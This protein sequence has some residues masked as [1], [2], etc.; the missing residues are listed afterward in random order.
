MGFWHLF[1]IRQKGCQR[2]AMRLPPE[3]YQMLQTVEQHMPQLR[4]SQIKGLVLWVYGT[5]LAGSSC[6]NA[7][8]AALS[9]MGNYN[10]LRQ[11]IR[12]WLY[13]GQDRSKPCQVQLDVRSCF[14]PLLRW[15][16]S[17]W[18]S[19][20]LVLAIDPTMKA[21]KLN[22]IVISV[23]Y[24]SCAIPV[25]WHILPANSPGQW[26][27]PV[28]DLL[29]LLSSA[30]PKDKTVLV[31]CDRGLRSPRLWE[32]IRS[33]G[34]H[35]YVR[36]SINTVFCPDGG[37]RLPARYLVPGPGHAWVGGGTAFRATSIRRRGTM[38]VVWDKD[39]QEPWV[40]MTDLPPAEA[41]VCWYALR[42]WIELGFK[43][44][45]SVGWQWQKTRRTDPERVSRHWLVLS[46]STLLALAYGTRV[47]D[48]SG[49][50]VNPSRL[51]APPKFV[52][53]THRSATNRP[54]R[55]V[56]VLRQGIIWLNRLLLK[57]R[58]WQRVWLLP[59]AWPEPS[60]NLRMIYGT[61]T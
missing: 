26:I 22:S 17:L 49:L 23:V 10:S 36:Q 21:D 20:R 47:E 25:A 38:I 8:S 45:K 9:V 11:Y 33:S 14:V 35:P 60:P 18:Q 12:E 1:G 46:V 32:Q 44:I 29:A 31:M 57:G 48:A 27:S 19:D 3:C 13:D 37:T 41:G 39:Q 42:F 24:R 50:G 56:S 16:L 34:W 43:A 54:R 2:F 7:V 55:I 15:V 58:L 40:V 4:H 52:S 61:D 6:Q 30:V 28:V 51:R 53:P 5:I 59:E